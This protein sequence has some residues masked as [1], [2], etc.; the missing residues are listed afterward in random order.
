MSSVV[1]PDCRDQNHQKCPGDAWDEAHDHGT[2]CQCACHGQQP[3]DPRLEAAARAIQDE[4]LALH[5][6][7]CER[8]ARS[9]LSAADAV[10]PLRKPG[11]RVQISQF[12][13][14]LQHPSEC[15]PN[16][17]ACPVNAALQR[18]GVSNI[19]DG[20]WAVALDEDEDLCFTTEAAP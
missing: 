18:Q 15:R 4:G 6:T 11:H 2:E 16:L 13:W 7:A 3:D 8:F 10:D 19:D 9:A 20:V 1:S 5:P 17:L 14:T 12:S